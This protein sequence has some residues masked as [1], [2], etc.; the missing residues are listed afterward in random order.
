MRKYLVILMLLAFVKP[1]ADAEGFRAPPLTIKKK[2]AAFKEKIGVPK[3]RISNRQMHCLKLNLYHEARGEGDKG[4]IEVMKVTKARVLSRKFPNTICKVVYQKNQF[5]WTEDGK[6]DTVT[7][8]QV[9]KHIDK[10]VKRHYHK[11]KVN[12]KVLYYHSG[13]LPRWF[14][15]AGLVK[16]KKVGNHLFYKEP[17]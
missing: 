13:P 14:R 2:I 9:W 7:D 5:E 10:L 16:V 12:K 8:K 1:V 6:P 15:S 4:M 11:L 17:I 3:K